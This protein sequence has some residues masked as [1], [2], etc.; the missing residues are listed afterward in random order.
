MA[1]AGI[2]STQDLQPNSDDNF[3]G[4][5]FD[6]IT[7]YVTNTNPGFGGSCGAHTATGNAAP[8]VNAGL[9]TTIP[10][11]TPFTLTGS[12]TD[13]NGD[14]LT[15]QWEEFDLGNA[16]TINAVLPNNDSS[17][18]RPI[19]RSYKPVSSPARI[20]PALVDILDGS[21]SNIGEALPRINRTMTFRL[22]ARDNKGG[23]NNDAMNVT[24]TN[25]SGPFRVTA[26][27]TGTTWTS[28][29]LQTV[30]WNV[31]NTTAA[32]VSCANVNILFSSDDGSN[33]G[34]T[35]LANTPNDG[36]ETITAPIFGTSNGRV[37]VACSGNIFF[38]ISGRITLIGNTPIN[39]YLPFII[40][41]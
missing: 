5:S 38:H 11:S 35:L 40:Q 31:A 7:A 28:A 8:T 41:E 34:N 27:L 24:V 6:E 32:P 21:L 29:T 22:T 20:F 17:G 13:P 15:Y 18:A 2:C 10:I 3:H 37:K 25:T 23:V 9:N 39:T 33:F 36:T 30:S 26:P 16:W 12:A 4:I 14:T 1:Y 19:F